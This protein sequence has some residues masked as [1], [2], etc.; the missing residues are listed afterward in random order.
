MTEKDGIRVFGPEDLER[1]PKRKA[2]ANK[3][4]YGHVLV[5]AGSEGMCGAAYLSALAAYRTGAGLVR[6][7]TPEPNRPILQ[8]LL[9]E[10]IVSTYD[11]GAVAAGDE[12]WKACLEEALNW[13]DVIVL[14]PGLGRKPYVKRLVEDV[15]EAAFV[16]LVV[17][18][19]ALNT[20][21]EFPYLTGYYTENI[22]ITP[23]VAE[24]AR[25]VGK[26]AGEVAEDLTASARDYRDVHGVTCLLKSDRSVIAG[27]DGSLTRT[28]AGTPAL[29]KGGTG[30]VLTGIIAGLICLGLGEAEAA[31]FGSFLHALCGRRAAE[32]LSVHGVLAREVAEEIPGVMRLVPGVN[33]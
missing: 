17:D 7:L 19:D 12:E 33:V 23:H 27:N 20:I 3:G 15:L 2:D 14:G 32:K 29:A 24:M 11:P 16:T 4:T 26:T 1:I 6:V 13:A 22:I 28:E 21:A 5:I 31:A 30:D 8:I 9:P 25:L 18:A 10:A